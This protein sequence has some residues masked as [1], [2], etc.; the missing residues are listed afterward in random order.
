MKTLK[1]PEKDLKKLKCIFE[2]ILEKILKNRIV[3]DLST[4]F[5]NIARK[6]YRIFD[7]HWN[8]LVEVFRMLLKC[9]KLRQFGR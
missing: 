1:L 3:G 4:N 8:D 2:L 6:Y 5:G 9:G 7:T